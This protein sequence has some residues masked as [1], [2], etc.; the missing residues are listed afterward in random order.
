MT[1]VAIA[2]EKFL[3]GFWVGRTP[4]DPRDPGCATCSNSAI[5][6]AIQQNIRKWKTLTFKARFIITKN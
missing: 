4:L 2:V 1:P 5:Y 6:G 3:Q